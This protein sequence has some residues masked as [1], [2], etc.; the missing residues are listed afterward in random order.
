MVPLLVGE[1]CGECSA[2][3]CLEDSN[4]LGPSDES[5]ATL[6]N[7]FSFL[8]PLDESLL[9]SDFTGFRHSSQTTFQTRGLPVALKLNT[10]FRLRGEWRE[11][12]YKSKKPSS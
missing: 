6:A 3:A 2:G 11:S 9:V 7:P 5:G 1:S 8:T 10:C 12:W 4:A